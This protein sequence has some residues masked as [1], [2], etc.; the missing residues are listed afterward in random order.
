MKLEPRSRFVV[1][2]PGFG[3]ATFRGSGHILAINGSQSPR[4]LPCIFK[5]RAVAFNRQRS[6]MSSHYSPYTLTDNMSDKSSFSLSV[7]QNIRPR[8]TLTPFFNTAPIPSANVATTHS[9]GPTIQPALKLLKQQVLR[10]PSSGATFFRRRT[11]QRM[12][13]PKPKDPRLQ[14]SLSSI[15][16]PSV[17]RR[18]YMG[19]QFHRTL[20]TTLHFVSVAIQAQPSITRSSSITHRQ[21]LCRL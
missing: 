21:L 11:G 15:P 2:S 5:S 17:F 7:W 3:R 19:P 12:R 20:V 10:R 13:P 4:G 14:R 6:G 1:T 8:S 18:P 9:R 16:R